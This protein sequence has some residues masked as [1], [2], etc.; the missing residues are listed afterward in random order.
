MRPGTGRKMLE[1]LGSQ[2]VFEGG[3]Q[4]LPARITKSGRWEGIAQYQSQ[5]KRKSGWFG[6]VICLW[7]EQQ[8]CPEPRTL[9]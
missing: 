5:D 3:V 2:Q 7:D 1:H 4:L 9:S 6:Y 8:I